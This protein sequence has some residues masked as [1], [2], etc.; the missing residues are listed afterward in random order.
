M[1]TMLKLGEGLSAFATLAGSLRL[2]SSPGP[3]QANTAPATPA[4]LSYLEDPN[5][6]LSR[7]QTI[8][9]LINI[10]QT[11]G[12]TSFTQP[13][14]QGPNDNQDVRISN[15]LAIF[16]VRESNVTAVSSSKKLQWDGNLQVLATR[17]PEP[18]KVPNS[19]PESSKSKPQ[20]T[21]SSW[22]ESLIF[23]VTQN[24][25]SDKPSANQVAN[26]AKSDKPSANQVVHCRGTGKPVGFSPGTSPG[27]GPGLKILTRPKPGPAT[28]YP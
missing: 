13:S 8:T 12:G 6:L 25:K 23:W 24:G 15:A 4:E 3:V 22:L 5:P 7:F 27:L 17:E 10:L 9:N 19:P 16:L 14:F 20:V 11:V 1:D 26:K 21:W 28:G 18:P 2:A